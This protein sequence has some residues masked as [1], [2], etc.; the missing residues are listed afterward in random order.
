MW[1]TWYVPTEEEKKFWKNSD[2]ETFQ[3]ILCQFKLNILTFIF[4][5]LRFF[6]FICEGY[7]APEILE[8]KKYGT[9]GQ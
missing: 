7:V 9:Y 3:N 4:L 2:F 1:Y 6:I 8:G 5:F